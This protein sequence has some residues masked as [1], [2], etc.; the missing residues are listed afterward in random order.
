MI[1]RRAAGSTV[2]ALLVM[3]AG[4]LPPS[5][6]HADSHVWWGQL[7]PV[8]V[9]VWRFVDPK[10][11]DEG[12]WTSR[13][14][15]A[16]AAWAAR[17]GD[18]LPPGV[19]IDIDES[20]EH[21]PA[22]TVTLLRCRTGDHRCA[23]PLARTVV[24]AST[25]SARVELDATFAAG[26]LAAVERATGEAPTV[27][28]TARPPALYTIQMGSTRSQERAAAWARRIDSLY[29][30]DGPYVF[31]QACGDCFITPQARVEDDELGGETI[32]RVIV[33]N[34]ES[35]RLARL[36]LAKLTRLG[37]GGGAIRPLAPPAAA[38]TGHAGR[39]EAAKLGRHA[40][41]AGPRPLRGARRLARRDHR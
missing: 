38:D 33:G 32:H 15:T 22:V 19:G 12:G 14:A 37:F 4:A 20:F 16:F 8:K 18:A 3:L 27:R 5:V 6:A 11:G 41:A 25:L 35:P 36:D 13:E 21:D 24:D 2:M 30:H 28:E 1:A 34:Y 23:H 40:S 9:S 7:G 17:L 39:A 10:P 29:E 26:I 31:D